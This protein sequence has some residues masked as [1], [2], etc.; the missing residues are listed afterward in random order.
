MNLR[1]VNM[2]LDSTHAQESEPL[3]TSCICFETTQLKTLG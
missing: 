1:C 2:K 3:S